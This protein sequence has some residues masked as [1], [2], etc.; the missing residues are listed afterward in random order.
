MTARQK[1]TAEQLWEMPEVPGKRFELVDGKVVE[2]PGA[3]VQHNLI[4]NQVSELIRPIVR[5][6]DPGLVL[7]DGTGHIIRRDL[8]R[9]LIPEVAFTSWDRLP[10]A[11]EPERYSPV[12]PDLAVEIVSPNDRADDVHDKVREYLDAGTRMVLV[13][14][15]GSRS[16]TVYA[17]GADPR[18]PG[19]DDELEGGDVLPGFRVRVSDLF[20]VQTSRRPSQGAVSR[21]PVG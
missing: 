12:P 8:D 10:E 4:A 21:S 1:V 9:V 20:E 6:G 7:T 2:V 15:P 14:W 16:A 5:E 11:W 3:G 19:P 13:L 17:Q 18:E